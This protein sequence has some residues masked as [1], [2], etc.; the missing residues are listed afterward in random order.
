MPLALTDDQLTVI[1]RLAEPVIYADRA[2]YLERVAQ[3]LR[4]REIRDGV[5]YRAA[6]TAQK[7]FRRMT[8][9]EDRG[10]NS[11]GKYGR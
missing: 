11:G 1:Q 7:E 3:L 10:P 5:V 9:L 8:V 2:R 6:E 4:G